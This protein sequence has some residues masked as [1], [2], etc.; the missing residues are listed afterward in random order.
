VTTL[1]KLTEFFP[2]EDYH[3]D[4]VTN[5]PNQSYVQACSLPKVHK[6]REAFKDWLK[7]EGK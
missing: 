3:Q 4:Y 5:N 6:V 1:E 7:E 2:A